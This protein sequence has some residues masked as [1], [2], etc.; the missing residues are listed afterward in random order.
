MLRQLTRALSRQLANISRFLNVIFGIALFS[1]TE[2]SLETVDAGRQL[3]EILERRRKRR[4]ASGELCA[5]N[6]SEKGDC[7]DCLKTTLSSSE[8][9]NGI[10]DDLVEL[11]RV[12][13]I[14]TNC[15]Q[16][17]L[18]IDVANEDG[19]NALQVYTKQETYICVN[20]FMVE[21]LYMFYFSLSSIPSIPVRY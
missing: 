4:T 10:V 14:V 2:P 20:V 18:L 11:E 16:Q 12:R 15:C 9:S 6:N 7:L 1:H 13:Q 19:Y 5:D 8:R 21:G 17:N 3:F